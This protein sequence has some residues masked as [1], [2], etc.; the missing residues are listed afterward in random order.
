MTVPLELMG[1]LYTEATPESLPLGASPICIN[2][3]FILGSVIQRPGLFS[4][5]Y[6]TNLFV[7]NAANFGQNLQTAAGQVAWANPNNISIKTPGTYASVILNTPVVTQ[8]GLLGLESTNA[9]ATGHSNSLTTNPLTA[10]NPPQLAI[11]LAASAQSI[12]PSGAWTVPFSIGQ[13][14]YQLLSNATP[15]TGTATVGAVA[16]WAGELALYNIAGTLAPTFVQ[17]SGSLSGFLAPG[18]TVFTFTN[19]LTAKNSV[20]VIF[21]TTSSAPA[22]FTAFDGPGDTFNLQTSFANGASCG[23]RLLMASNVVGGNTTVTFHNP[24][25]GSIGGFYV[26][27]EVQGGVLGSPSGGVSQLLEA[28]NFAFSIPSTE[29][30]LGLQVIVSGHQTSVTP[31]AVLTANLFN[32]TGTSATQHVFQLPS[33][34][35]S[36]V[37]GVP[38]DDWGFGPLTNALLNDPNFGVQ[39]QASATTAVTFDIYKVEVKVYVTPNPAPNFNYLKSFNETGGEILNLALGGDG[40]LYQEDAI[41]LPGGLAPVFTQILPGSFAQSCTQDDREFIAVSNLQNGTDIPRTYSPPNLDRL[42]Q[43]GPGAPLSVVSSGTSAAST[44]IVSVTQNPA[45]NIPTAPSGTSGAWIVWSDSPQDNGSFGAPKTPGNVFTI[46]LPSATPVPSY[47]KV[48]SNIVMS[49][50]QTMNGYDPNSG[51]GSNPAFYT[52]T[53]IGTPVSGQQY[54]DAITFT[55]PQ[56]GFYN[57]R[58]QAGSKIQ[59][60]DA[61]MTTS[62]QVQNLEVGNSFQIAGTGGG[63]PSGYDGTWNVETTPNAS[64]LNITNTQLNGSAATY[65]YTLITGTNPVANQTITVTQTTNGNGIFN[66]NNAV[67]T[68]AGPGT[69]TLQLSNPNN[70]TINPQGEH[71]NGIIFGT[72]FTFDPQAIIGTKSG[73]TASTSGKIAEGTRKLCY[74][75]LT[76]NGYVTQPSPIT[77]I[78]VG[79]T[80]GTLSVS[81]LLVGPPNVIA[82]IIHSTAADGGNF[83]NIPQDVKVDDNGTI[84]TSH[85]TWVN[86]NT[87]TSATLDFTDGVLLAADQIDIDGNNLFENIELGSCTALVPYAQRMFAIGE[88]N[89]VMNFLNWSFD[90]GVMVVGGNAS[91]GGATGTQNTYPAGWT[92]DPT[93]GGG[94]SVQNSPIFGFAYQISNTTGSPQAAYGMITQGAYQDEFLVPII[95]A[96]TTYSVRLAAACTTGAASGNLV[97]DLFSAQTSTVYGS[98]SLPLASMATSQQI[99][100]GTM[101]VTT[102]APVPNDLVLRL[103]AQ[104][105]PNNTTIVIDR[106]EP[107]PTETPN[108]SLQVIGSYQSAFEQ[109]DRLT[110]VVR[111]DQQ[112]QQPVTSGFVLF[113]TMYL[114][115]LGSIVAVTDNNTTEPSEWNIPRIVSQSVGTFGPYGV[116]TGIDN[117]N[118]GEEWSL[119]AGLQGLFIFQ[120]SQPIKLSEEI[121]KLWNFINWAYGYTMWIQND[122]INRR[123]MVGVPMRT[124]MTVSGVTSS[125][126]YIPAGVLAPTTNPTTP[127]V[128]I[129][130]NYNQLNTAGALAESVEIHRSYSGKLIASD[131]VRKW[132]IWTIQAPCAAPL[133]RADSTEPMFVGNSSNTGKVYELVDDLQEDDGQPINQIYY[134]AGFVPTET[135]EGMQMGVMRYTFEYATSVITGSGPVMIFVYPNALFGPYSHQLLPNFTLG[136]ISNGDLELPLNETGSRMYMSFQSNAVSTKFELSRLI[137]VMSPDPWSPVRGRND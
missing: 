36:V 63:P 54:Y 89:K 21:E 43:V 49:G 108:N 128:V 53:S 4:F 26:A 121:R 62:S 9:V 7:D 111:C 90:G 98:F 5:F 133:R 134:T 96:S 47:L 32:L 114:V 13:F 103:W 97:V 117:P 78:T 127:N 68:S 20:F 64:Q 132:S 41:A 31:D 107:F 34:D 60:T 65:S 122:I 123:I 102:L 27:V 113:G 72:I 135:G 79:S 57:A 83:Y 74:S 58:F 85:S 70:T 119:I 1:G 105:I 75:F 109:F 136:P 52:I 30:I 22:S 71:G 87:D 46:V 106:V 77:T 19:P 25:G 116:T 55:L 39:I 12:T 37:L 16:D 50:V 86:N 104:N 125:N 118:T 24:T 110:G 88:Q 81:N 80:A 137:V 10:D 56:S 14:S 44:S 18:D 91:A 40:T 66:V 94:A 124:S 61:T 48:G 129:E 73:G 126:V 99:Y 28:M 17:K 35:G 115:K 82:R 8:N 92:V 84:V 112:N 23:M 2:C 33:V 29:N 42:T 3:D 51:H 45:F 130:L 93:S 11:M 67:I 59:A 69:F 38:L 6:F 76:R 100:T 120:G 15:V 131:I 101:L 95:E